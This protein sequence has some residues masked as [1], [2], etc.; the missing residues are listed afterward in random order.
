MGTAMIIGGCALLLAFWI[1]PVVLGIRTAGTKGISPHWMWFGFHPFGAW[2]AFLVIRFG[3]RPRKR[4]PQCSETLLSH[5][6]LCPYCGHSFDGSVE[7]VMASHPPGRRTWLIV[8]AVVGGFSLFMGVFVLA[9]FAM[10]SGTF[11]RSEVVRKA[12]AQAQSDATLQA[13]LGAPI[14]KHWTIY[15]SI[16][17]SGPSGNADFD[18]PLHGPKGSG[19]L[20]VVATKSADLWSFTTLE[21]QADGSSKRVDLLGKSRQAPPA[22]PNVSK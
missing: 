4:C 8:V 1:V 6:K 10:T 5:A 16:N 9:I 2:I 7:H 20:F 22:P 17:E 18:I 3:L 11:D 15:G 13:S 14:E 12:L 21:F 19:D